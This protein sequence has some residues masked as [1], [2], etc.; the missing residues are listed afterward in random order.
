MTAYKRA[1]PGTTVEVADGTILPVGG[2]GTIEVDLGQ[3]DTTTKP[4]KVVTVAAVPGRLRNPAV[5]L[6]SSKPMG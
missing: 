6:Q 2:F 4:V 3:P 5:H 1:S